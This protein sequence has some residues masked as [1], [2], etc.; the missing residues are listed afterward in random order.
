MGKET[1]ER[2]EGRV[3]E[4]GQEREEWEEREERERRGR[5]EDDDPPP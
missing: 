4:E 3:M 1:N 5:K 2:V